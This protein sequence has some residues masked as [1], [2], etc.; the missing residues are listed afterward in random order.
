MAGKIL[1]KI[2]ALPFISK[3]ITSAKNFVMP[4]FE[5]LT[6]YEVGHFFFV[7]CQKSS[8]TIRAASVSFK[9]FLA[10]FPAIIFLFSLLPYL[11]VADLHQQLLIELKTFLPKEA[12]DS[13]V[14]TINDLI[15]NQHGKLL[16]F[17][18]LLTLYV[19]TNGINALMEAFNNSFHVKETRN[20][21]MQRLLSVLLLIILSVL[22]LTATVIIIFSG[23]VLDY[24]EAKGLLSGGFDTF[25]INSLKWIIVLILFFSA[26]SILYY[27]GPVKKTRYR[28]FSAGATLATVLSIVASLGFNFYVNNFGTYNKVYGSI[29]TLMVIM[30]WMNFNSLI[31]I[32]GFDLNAKIY[33]HEKLIPENPEP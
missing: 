5:G 27:F 10:I 3:T 4:G 6:L 1:N 11:P 21:W 14:E 16:S 7:E 30:L 31:I 12:Y 32:I 22:L 28:F 2:L 18:F 13:A 19:S 20:P 29:G 23:I 24:F 8:L 17:G 25:L 15:N 26:I 33:N 9:F